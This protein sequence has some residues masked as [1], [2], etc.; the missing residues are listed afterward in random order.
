[1]AQ[2]VSVSEALKLVCPFKGD[3]AEV[4]AFISNVDTAFEVTDPERADVLYKFV[5]SRISGEPRVA[6]THRGL[7]NWDELRAFLKNTY[8]EKRTLDYHATQLFGARQGKND[9]ISGWIQNVQK[10]SSKFREAALQDCEEDERVGI[11]ALADKLRNICFVQGIASDRIQTIVRTRNSSTFDEIAETALE[12]ESAIYSKN[13]RYR[14]GPPP[15]RV[16]CNN[17]GKAGHIAAKCYLKDKKDA[18]VNKLGSETQGRTQKFQGS[19]RAEIKCYNCGEV[20]HMAR[21]CK[22]PRHMRRN[23]PLAESVFEGRPPDRSNPSI[24]SVNTVGCKNGTATECISMRS[25]IIN[26][27]ELLL[28]VD[29]GADIS[30]LK[31]DHLDKTKQFDPKGRVKV[32]GVSGSTIQTLGSPNCYV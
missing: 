18:R 26:G 22:K 31:P 3:K 27:N 11:V 29:T 9:S 14:Q 12:E 30:L 7:E 15:S 32:K 13:D 1:M 20:G 10:L 25:E 19:R 8:T 4:L 16:T 5:L 2:Y 28:L 21:D 24:G 6:I 17:C 23:I